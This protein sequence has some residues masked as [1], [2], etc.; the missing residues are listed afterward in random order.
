MPVGD[1]SGPYLISAIVWVYDL[2]LYGVSHLCSDLCV[3]ADAV[4]KNRMKSL[5]FELKFANEGVWQ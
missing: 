3:L 5:C 2:R 4:W 1:V